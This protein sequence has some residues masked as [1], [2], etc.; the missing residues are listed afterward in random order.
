MHGCYWA[1]QTLFSELAICQIEPVPSNYFQ[2]GTRHDRE[3][4]SAFLVIVQLIST[5]AYALTESFS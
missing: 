5:T 2:R 4:R 3:L 1:S